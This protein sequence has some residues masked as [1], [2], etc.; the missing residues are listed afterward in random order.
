MKVYDELL[1]WLKMGFE[2]VHLEHMY[3]LPIKSRRQ[4][5]DVN[6]QDFQVNVARLVRFDYPTTPENIMGCLVVREGYKRLEKVMCYSGTKSFQRNFSE[7][8][9]ITSSNRRRK[10]W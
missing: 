2:H 4:K 1:K 5:A 6:F 7:T 3:Q 10:N 8:G 9:R